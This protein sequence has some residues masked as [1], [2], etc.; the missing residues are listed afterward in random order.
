MDIEIRGQAA[1]AVAETIILMLIEHRVM[2][3]DYVMCALEAL[4]QHHTS[5]ATANHGTDAERQTNSAIARVIR[6]FMRG[7]NFRAA[8]PLMSDSAQQRV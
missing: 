7:T 6:D 4:L 3:H 5:L 8:A 2:P 1:L